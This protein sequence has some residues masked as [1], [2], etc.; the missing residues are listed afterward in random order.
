MTVWKW[1]CGRGMTYVAILF[2]VVWSNIVAY[3]RGPEVLPATL[4]TLAV[5]IL[6]MVLH[7]KRDKRWA[8]WQKKEDE[9]WRARHKEMDMMIDY[10]AGKRG[11]NGN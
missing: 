7:C 4:G 2:T 5:I 10:Y 8:E 6:V 9:A 1:L 3:L 11:R